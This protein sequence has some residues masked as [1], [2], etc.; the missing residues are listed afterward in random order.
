MDCALKI[1]T[2]VNDSRAFT[3]QLHN[4]WDHVLG[5]L[6]SDNLTNESRSSEANKVDLLSVEVDGDIDASFTARN[7]ILIHIFFTKLGDDGSSGGRVFG[8]L[9]DTAISSNDSL[10]HGAYGKVE[11]V[12]PGSVNTNDTKGLVMDQS[13]S[14]AGGVL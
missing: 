14:G 4:A 13:F 6:L 5:C 12:V 3:S 2:L 10:E 9:D 11:G 1:D 8:R 7:S